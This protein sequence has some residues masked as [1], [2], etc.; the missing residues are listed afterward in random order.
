[1]FL[2]CFFQKLLFYLHISLAIDFK[3]F[4]LD[5]TCSHKYVE[6]KMDKAQRL[7][8]VQMTGPSYCGVKLQVADP[9]SGLKAA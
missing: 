1:M 8:H 5:R 2:I 4:T 9:C 6:P 7:F 3:K